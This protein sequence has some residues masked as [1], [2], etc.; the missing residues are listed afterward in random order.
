MINKR[1]IG[2]VPENRK[3]I[4]GNVALQWLSLVANIVM[5]TSI[6][7]LLSDLYIYKETST[8]FFD[9]VIVMLATMFVRFGCAAGAS[10]MSYLSSKEVKKTLRRLIYEKLLRLGASYQEQTTTSEVVQVA[11]EGVDQLETYFGAYLPQFFYAMLA[12][13]TLFIYLCFINMPS[14]VVLLI[15][16]PLIPVAI[17]AVQ[18]WAKKLLSKYWGQYTALGDTFLENLQGLT[19]LKIYQS[20]AY[21]NEE[22]N[23]E[24]E[25]F[26]KITMKVLAMQLNSITIMDFIA[27]G[28]AA[29]GI[30][31][32][33][34]QMQ[35]GKVNLSGCLLIIL[36]AADFFI[37]MRQLGSFFH[38]AMNG[39]AASEK[40]FRLLDLP[41]G[42]GKAADVD[43]SEGFTTVQNRQFPADG[44]IYLE[45]V[46]FAY[47]T[48]R[49]ILHGVDLLL[50]RGKFTAI[51][52]ESGCGK[53][54][55]SGILMGRNG[56]YSGTVRVGTMDY[57]RISEKSLMQN[58]T[59]V[60]HQ[61]YLFR[62]TV[63][64]NLRMGCPEASD[65]KLWQILEKV[66][67]ADFLRSE[68]GLNTPVQ[69][70]GS[71]FSG[72]QCQRL[73]LA[74]A[75]LHDSPVYIFDEA[76][77][78]IDVES[79]NDIMALIRELAETGEKTILLISHRLANV[80]SADRI[81]VMDAGNVTEQGT[82]EDLLSQNGTY[83][84]LWNAQQ[85]LENYG[86]GGA[87]A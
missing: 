66:R 7:T 1:L 36:L 77:S 65:E 74:R 20:D 40:I 46:H 14:A 54:T 53:S 17:A 38:I 68:Q 4:A 67:L 24:S 72:G 70:K 58:V 28:G 18:T 6:T 13:L 37:P 76:T 57:H 32:S 85:S 16:V 30:I 59:Y 39:M 34:S 27:Y 41:E 31:L 50:S 48:D 52:G 62:G 42:D 2:I 81:Y 84:K 10:K 63:S 55:I 5:M 56:G 45:Q 29:L 23:A 43:N 22:M 79:E 75:L 3:Y 19:T 61:S 60:S 49:E 80:V 8:V 87:Q 44:D 33:V 83:A 15:C 51:V 11:V 69:E 26:R 47:E 21:K 25:K 82:Q 78:N 12:P 86:K 71:N 35:A 9:T 64:D 73:A